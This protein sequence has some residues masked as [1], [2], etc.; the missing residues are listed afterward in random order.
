MCQNQKCVLVCVCFWHVYAIKDTHNMN[1]V[2]AGRRECGWECFEEHRYKTCFLFIVVQS[3]CLTL[4]D[5]M[6]CSVPGFPVL[7]Y[8]PEFVHT[9]VH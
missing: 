5:P 3:L 7:H 1:I 6:N 2:E 9:H 4:C 8:L